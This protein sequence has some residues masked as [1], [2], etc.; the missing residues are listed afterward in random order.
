MARDAPYEQLHFIT[1]QSQLHGSTAAAAQQTIAHCQK[2]HC[3]AAAR[4]G[5]N[6]SWQSY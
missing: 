2:H 6:H 5:A 1:Q 4:D 3:N